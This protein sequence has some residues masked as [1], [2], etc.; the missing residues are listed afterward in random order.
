L[1][2]DERGHGHD[3]YWRLR[4]RFGG[5]ARTIYLG[6]DAQ[7]V[8]AVRRELNELQRERNQARRITQVASDAKKMLRAAK[9]RLEPVLQQL[10]VHYHG[11]VMRKNRGD[12]KVGRE[13]FVTFITE[14][15]TMA[16]S[17]EIVDDEVVSETDACA[18]EAPAVDE[19]PVTVPFDAAYDHRRRRIFDLRVEA[20]EEPDTRIACLT[21]MNSDLLDT[22]LTVAETLRQGLT[23]GGGSLETIERHHRLLDW[24]L[25]YSK[26]ITQLTQLEQRVRKDNGEGGSAR[27]R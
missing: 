17:E 20:Q 18:G 25:R 19:P 14:D 6:R 22:E 7:F 10:G 3:G 16:D 9:R 12:K 24:V 21:G 15:C 26:Q 5:R 27:P 4:F 1:T 8:A 23:A 11:D 13:R 2:K